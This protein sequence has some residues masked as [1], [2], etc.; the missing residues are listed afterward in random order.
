MGEL[1]NK[2]IGFWAFILGVIIFGKLLGF[3]DDGKTT[4]IILIASAIVY[5]VWII[6]RGKAKAKREQAEWEKS[7]NSPVRKGQA[8]GKK[9]KR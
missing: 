8:K 7:M 4:I 9:K 6:A 2:I 5:L 1:L 3:M